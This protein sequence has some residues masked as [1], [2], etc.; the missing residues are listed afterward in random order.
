VVDAL[1]DA[2]VDLVLSRDEAGEPDVVVRVDRVA[3]ARIVE[4]GGSSAEPDAE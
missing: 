3:V 4:R 1:A 2:T